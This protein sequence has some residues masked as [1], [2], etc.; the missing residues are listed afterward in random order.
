M[1]EK[2]EFNKAEIEVIRFEKND[3]IATSTMT[4]VV[5]T[6]PAQGFEE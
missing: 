2:K 3:I 1:K 4:I 5:D 6:E